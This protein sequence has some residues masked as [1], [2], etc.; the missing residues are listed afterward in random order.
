MTQTGWW[1]QARVSLRRSL[2]RGRGRLAC[3]T[4]ATAA[5]AARAAVI[6]QPLARPEKCDDASL[7]MRRCAAAI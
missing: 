6:A 2:Y 1:F 3:G 7:M 4:T 5:A